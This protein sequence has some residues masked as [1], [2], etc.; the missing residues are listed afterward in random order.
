MATEEKLLTG[1]SESNFEQ[2]ERSLNGLSGTEP[3]KVRRDAF[4]AFRKSGFP[5]SK[6]ED[7]KYTN[8][9][10]LAEHNFALAPEVEDF[11]EIDPALFYISQQDSNRIVLVNGFFVSELS[12]VSQP[13]V[14]LQT[15]R[16]CLN[17]KGSLPFKSFRLAQSS[18]PI[19]AFQSAFVRDGLFL[20]VEKNA[21]VQKPI[22]I[23]SIW[24]ESK[25]PTLST[26][27]LYVHVEQGAD[28]TV[29]EQHRSFGSQ[30]HLTARVAE[31]FVGENARAT[32]YLIQN[33]NQENLFHIGHIAAEQQRSSF[34][35]TTTFA[36]GGE[37]VRNEATVKIDGEGCE[38]VLN[39]LSVLS[40]KQHV[41]NHTVLDHAKPNCESHELYKGIYDG[42]SE[43]VFCGTI[44]V[45]P[46][47]QKTNAIQSNDALLLSDRAKINSKPQLKIWADDVKCTHGA[48]VGQLDKDALFYVRSRGVGFY[49]A[50][51]MLIRAFAGA[52]SKE[53]KNA[54]LREAI[55]NRFVEKLT[56]G[57]S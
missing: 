57:R 26:P 23:L 38:T 19:V 52:V 48:T 51:D 11:K 6:H 34:F 28:I 13:G 31:F 12:S 2:L 30:V 55:E 54:E 18:N 21:V 49:D 3:H 50:R 25:G 41:D 8:L 40:G 37:L 24:T 16:D 9:R 44:I 27:R 5:T 47:A 33:E 10:P 17:Q 53:I 1:W 42:S 14:S 29:V 15:F 20:H 43:G 46:D 22:E 35:S 7:W 39:G 36:F 4:E 32:H 56:A 45:R